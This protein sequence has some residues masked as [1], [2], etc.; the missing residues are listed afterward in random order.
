[1]NKTMLMGRLTKD[2]EVRYS[3]SAEPIAIARYTLAVNRK[4]KKQ[5]EPDADFIPI[6]A[7]GKQGEF[8]EKYFKK[9]Q[10]VAICGRIQVRTWDK[11][12]VKQWSTEIVVEDQ[13]FADSKKE[14][15][16][17][18][19]TPASQH[20]GFYPIDGDDDPEDLPF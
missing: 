4:F 1:M 14:G 5:G 18:G 12:G 20:E 15:G 9:G 13:Y 10:Q 11:D 17:Q 2:P 3:Q 6:V 7:F 8:A 19:N 16:Q